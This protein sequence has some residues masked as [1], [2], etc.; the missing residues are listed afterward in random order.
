MDPDPVFKS[1]WIR[2]RFL[3]LDSDPVCTERLYPDQVNIRP[4]S[5]SCGERDDQGEEKMKMKV[6]K[7]EQAT[8]QSSGSLLVAYLVGKSFE[9]F[10]LACE[11]DIVLRGVISDQLANLI[12]DSWTDKVIGRSRFAPENEEKR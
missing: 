5:K 3:K 6:W 1:L 4:D 9:I 12:T 7:V 10:W 2:I 11:R 8:A